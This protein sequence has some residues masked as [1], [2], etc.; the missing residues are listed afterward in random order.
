MKD[1]V[2][3]ET[4]MYNRSLATYKGVTVAVYGVNK[5]E[6][7]LTRQDL[8]ELINVRGLGVVINERM[9]RINSDRRRRSDFHADTIHSFVTGKHSEF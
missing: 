8:V 3:V 7:S 4:H 1:A 2:P 6:I 5:A 9:N